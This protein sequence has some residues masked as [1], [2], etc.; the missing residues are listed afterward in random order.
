MAKI[1]INP[2]N[3]R[4]NQP[5]GEHITRIMYDD[6]EPP[7]NYIWGKPDGY[8]YQWNGKKWIKLNEVPNMHPADVPIPSNLN[9]YVSKTDLDIKLKS[10]KNEIVSYLTKLIN[11]KDCSNS[12]ESAIQWI[13]DNIVPDLRRLQEID[14][15]EF[16]T[17]EELEDAIGDV[18]LSNLATKDELQNAI[19]D[20]ASSEDI[21]NIE[22]VTSAALNDLND[23]IITLDNNAATK[24]ELQDAV[25][26]LIDDE[27]FSD[28]SDRITN[29]EETSA[30]KQAL[31]SHISSSDNAINSLQT[32]TTNLE[33]NSATKLELSQTFS[34]I[35]SSPVISGINSKIRTLENNTV[36]NG[37][38]V[39]YKNENYS[40]LNGLNGRLSSLERIDHT[41][42]IT[43]EDVS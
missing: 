17:K 43:A 26:N 12:D 13:N 5:G 27:V 35:E 28:I 21:V 42:F 3:L 20:I 10:L 36:K 29:L 2:G 7:K 6:N 22:K 4:K 8:L 9:N 32:R 25:S 15:D 34:S 31:S 23:R 38:F 33:T 37:D 1:T 18:D 24:S 19:S 39:D 16:A 11:N 41:Q 30:T 14:H 40:T